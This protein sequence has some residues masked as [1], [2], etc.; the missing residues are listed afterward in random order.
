M[1]HREGQEEFQPI[2]HEKNYNRSYGCNCPNYKYNKRQRYL[3]EACHGSCP[4]KTFSIYGCFT[5]LSLILRDSSCFEILWEI[6]M[7]WARID[8]LVYHL[9]L[10]TMSLHILVPSCLSYHYILNWQLI[11][12][13]IVF[14]PRA[15][16]N[17]P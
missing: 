16:N 12:K 17:V 11:F 8:L 9:S 14:W 10:T 13:I 2:F 5:F 1:V 3:G 4:L 6:S 15:N 7:Q